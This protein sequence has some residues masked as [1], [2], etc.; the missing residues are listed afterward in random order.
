MR[1]EIKIK[2]LQNMLEEITERYDNFISQQQDIINKTFQKAI[3]D[4]LTNLYNR[5][6][7]QE[8]GSNLE[9][10]H[11]KKMVPFHII[12]FDLDNFKQVNDREGHK[13]G[14]IILQKIAKVL[15]D[16]FP[17]DWIFRYG[18]DEFVVISDSPLKEI[19][20][21]IERLEQKVVE[22]FKEY[23]IGISWG[24]ATFPEDGTEFRRLLDVADS[25]MYSLKQQK[26]REFLRIF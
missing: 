13:S 7:L 2:L 21:E 22:T 5:N 11:L 1:E 25:R 18:G 20:G 15:K 23:Q 17:F 10:Q 9:K 8:Y 6:Y 4:P 24:I 12:F 14:D 3:R 26:K 16:Y 19:K